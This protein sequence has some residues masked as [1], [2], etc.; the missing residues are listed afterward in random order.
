MKK[1]VGSTILFCVFG[2]FVAM[3]AAQHG[4]AVAFAVWGISII[5]TALTAYAVRLIV[6]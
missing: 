5:L 2:A 3:T 4:V 1:V 6:D